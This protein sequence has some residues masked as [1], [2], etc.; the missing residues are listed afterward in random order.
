MCVLLLCERLPRRFSEQAVRLAKYVALVRDGY[1]GRFMD[2]GGAGIS[3]LLS[4]QGDFSSHARDAMRGT[5]GDA[6]DSFGNLSAAIGCIVGLFFLDVEVLCVLTY[7]D[8]ID[9]GSGRGG[10][11]DR[12]DIGVKV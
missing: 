4:P 3:N 8:K 9:G 5:L 10:G 6:F 7:D 1:E 12:T 11:L 2:A